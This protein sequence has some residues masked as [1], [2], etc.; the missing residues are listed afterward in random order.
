MKS[1][2]R[3]T[4][5][6]CVFALAL[7][8]GGTPLVACSDGDT[9]TGRRVTLEVNVQADPASK[10]FTNA[11]GWNVSVTKAAIATG[12]FYFFD[13]ETIFSLAP[14][15]PAGFSFVKSAFAHP[16]HYVPGTARGE[17]LTPSSVDLLAGGSLGRGNGIT[18]PVRSATFSF[19]APAK[20]PMANELGPNVIVVEGTATKG[21]ETRAFRAEIT[22]EEEKD[23]KGVTQIEGCPFTEVD[24]QAD[25]VVTLNVKLAQWFDQVDFESVPASTD[26]KPVLM[27]E[28]LPRN[29]LLRGTRVGL[30]YQFS[31]APR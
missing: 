11:Q 12:A 1:V 7:V 25:G 4:A 5:A 16:G 17:I 28:G 15:A 24:M 8:A 29:Q 26:G 23:T 3:A 20:G 13:G 22:S 18:G 14:R 19:D 6:A 30:A 9:T 21:A 27:T 10:Q 2:I 31:Y